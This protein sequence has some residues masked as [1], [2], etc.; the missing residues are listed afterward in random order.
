[1]RREVRECERESVRVKDIQHL[2]GGYYL[3][4]E[5]ATASLVM[6]TVPQF[7]IKLAIEAVFCGYPSLEI[8]RLR[9]N[10]NPIRQQPQ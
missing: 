1:M 9:E 7:A 8:Q 2:C 6:F 3:H 10:K 5:S 4:S